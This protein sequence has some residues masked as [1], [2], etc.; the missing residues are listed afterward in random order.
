MLCCKHI[1]FG[2]YDIL[3]KSVFNKLAWI[4]ISLFLNVTILIHTCTAFSDVLNI[5]EAAFRQKRSKEYTAKCNTF[6]VPD[7]C[8]DLYCHRLY[9]FLKHLTEIKFC[10]WVLKTAKTEKPNRLLAFSI[11]RV[12]FSNE[13]QNTLYSQY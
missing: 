9:E 7:F 3:R 4:W 11:V 12:Y 10:N 13:L 6:T 1:I 5:A 8:K 2:V